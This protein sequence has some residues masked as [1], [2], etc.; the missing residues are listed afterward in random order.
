MLT[1]LQT[2]ARGKPRNQEL[3]FIGI[4]QASPSSFISAALSLGFETCSLSI[5]TWRINN[6]Q[7][8]SAIEWDGS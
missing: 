3:A 7:R 2:S 5:R 4:T 6:D 1:A 8:L